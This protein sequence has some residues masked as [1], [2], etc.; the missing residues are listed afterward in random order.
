M[1]NRGGLVAYGGMIGGFLASCVLLPQARHPAAA[2]GRR[3]GA[4]GRARD[5]RSRASAASC[6]AATSARA[7]T[8][9]GRSASRAERA[10]PPHGQPGL[11]APRH[12]FGLARTAAWSFPVHPTQIY[13]SLVGLFLFA[14]LMLIRRYRT[15]SGQVFLGWVLGYGILRPLIEIV[16]D[17]DQRGQRPVPL[18]DVAVHRHRLGRARARPARLAAAQVPARSREPRASGCIRSRP[19]AAPAQR[20]G[21]DEAAA[22]A[23]SGADAACGAV[24]ARRGGG[25]ARRRRAARAREAP[26][27]VTPPAPARRRRA[28]SARRRR[29]RRE[30]RG[31]AA[32]AQQAA[33]DLEA[34]VIELRRIIEAIDR[35]ARRPSTTSAAAST[36]WTR[37]WARTTGA[38]TRWRCQRRGP[39]GVG[40]PVPRRR[41]RDPLARTG[42]SCWCPHL[43]LQTI[44]TGVI[45]SQG[46]ADAAAPDVSEFSLAARRG[47]PGGARRQPPVRVPVAA[48]RRRVADDQ[49]RLRRSWR[50]C[51]ASACAS[52]SS[53]SPT[54]C[55]AGPG[56]ASWSSSTSR[57]RWPRSR[58]SATSA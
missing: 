55:S 37:A 3:G 24:R 26:A 20:E 54:G 25:R 46:T 35:S 48:R 1:V 14:L 21:R 15:F 27:A 43:R 42:A 19:S 41:L 56:T 57:R 38:T 12:D 16:R 4:V 10:G 13:E 18:L 5:R 32:A 36:S 9:P 45:A 11:A 44:Y 47:D 50:P 8:C 53:R 17:D 6:S 40:V 34:Q 33:Q 28:A 52:G 49:R 51:A 58:W 39:R 29:R 22:S 31:Q 2:V 7:R 30:G 23:A